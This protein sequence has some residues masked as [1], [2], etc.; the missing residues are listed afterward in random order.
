MI[1]VLNFVSLMKVVANY[2]FRVL[3]AIYVVMIRKVHTA[4]LIMIVNHWKKICTLRNS[5]SSIND[6]KERSSLLNI[7]V[8]RTIKM[9]GT[10][11]II[12]A[13]MVSI[14]Y[15]HIYFLR[16]FDLI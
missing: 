2:L 15:I 11:M 3:I 7:L 12:K 9:I 5:W 4:T 13:T 14:L 1:I 8:D 6:S 16:K 10:K